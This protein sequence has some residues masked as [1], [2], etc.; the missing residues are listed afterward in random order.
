MSHSR[1]LGNPFPLWKEHRKEMLARALAAIRTAVGRNRPGVRRGFWVLPWI[2]P[3]A[4]S[5]YL[6]Y[7]LMAGTHSY[8]PGGFK[9]AAQSLGR[10]GGFGFW[11]KASFFRM[12]VIVA[13]LLAIALLF[14]GRLLPRR[15]RFI[16]VWFLSAGIT[17]ALYAQLRAFEVVGE[18]LSFGTF[19][20][21]VAW[22]WHEPGAY[23]SYLGIGTVLFTLVAVA[24]VFAGLWRVGGPKAARTENARSPWLGRLTTLKG[25]FVCCLVPI[26]IVSCLP[27]LPSSPYE[28]SILWRGLSAYWHESDV[29]TAQFTNLGRSGLVLQY[30]KLTHAPVPEKSPAYWGKAKGSNVIFFVLETMPARFLPPD[31]DM[32]DLPNLQRL[33]QK[34]FIAIRHYTTFPRTHEAVFSLLSS[35]YPSDV[36]RTLEEQHPDMKAPGMMAVLSAAGYRT[37]IYSPMRTETSYDGRMFESVGVQEQ[38]YP[39]DALAPPENRQ[40]LRA[41][42][43]KTRVARDLATLALMKQ[44]LAGCIAQ[45]QNF[46]G[47]FLPQIS[48]LPYPESPQDGQEDLREQ[49]R[50]ILQTED[51]WLGDLMQFLEREHQLDNTV[52]VITGDHGIRNSEEDPNFVGGMIDDYSFHVPLLIYAPRVLD[53]PVT[54]RWLTS[55]IDVAPTVLDLLG[56]ER[57]RRFE[58][59][60]PIWDAELTKRQTY[61][62]ANTVFGADGYYADGHFYMRNVV[63]DSVYAD[64]TQH[65]R[66]K[67]I[68][69][70]TSAER[71]EVSNSIARMV[72]LQQVVAAHFSQANKARNHLFGSARLED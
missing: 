16:A 44:D 47:V 30:R 32:S 72:G 15:P 13:A 37:A 8:G 20:T 31:G 42:W 22:G 34:S 55:H 58:E 40:D 65:F 54:I 43:M 69:P 12:D 46:A 1:I 17:V 66:T 33:R 48:H 27:R 59:G 35:W 51:G 52:I 61:F 19:W 3:A 64:V 45:R 70:S 11:Q 41:A 14:L 63:S 24:F 38:I 26:A 53:H 21:A 2:V 10:K 71:A 25:A 28:S 5:L 60:S 7:T 4:T 50:A 39:P 9:I 56:I 62:F 67:D 57:G 18:F 23:V 49:A 36:T 68:V 6:K 29:Q